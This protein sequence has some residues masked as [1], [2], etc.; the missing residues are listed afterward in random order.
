MIH[1]GI[2]NR[3]FTDDH[4]PFNKQ[5]FKMKLIFSSHTIILALAY[6][7]DVSD[8]L[9]PNRQST[10]SSRIV[11]MRRHL[12]VAYA[13]KI[14][15]LDTL[16]ASSSAETIDAPEVAVL[17]ARDVAAMKYR[18]LQRK[19]KEMGL[20]GTGDTAELRSR[21]MGK[22]GGAHAG[23]EGATELTE[24]KHPP[25][26]E[27]AA[28]VIAAITENTERGHWKKAVRKLKKLGKYGDTIPITVYENVLGACAEGRLSGAR[29]AEPAR[30]I[31]ENM[32]RADYV[33]PSEVGNEC[34]VNSLGTEVGGS[35]D[36]FG[37]IDTA[38]AMLAAMEASGSY[39]T[40]DAYA[41]VVEALSRDGSLDEAVLL[42]RAM[43]VEK[44]FTPPLSM[45]GN[46]ALAAARERMD[47]C[48]MNV[49]SLAKA[50]GYE[51]DSVGAAESGR[52]LL[53]AGLIAAERTDNLRLGLRILTAAKESKTQPDPCD[54]MVS[55]SSPAAQRASTLI[56]KRSI[57]RAVTEDNWK[58]AVRILQLMPVRGIL[59]STAIWRKVVTLCAKAGKS[60]KATALLLDWI[61]LA[62]Q[63]KV[64]KPPQ[65]VF[66][67][68]VNACEMCGEEAL[69]VAVLESM[70][71]TLGTSG[72]LIT[73]N[74][75]LKRLA[76]AGNFLA[77]EGI[78]I[79]M[80]ESGVEPNVVSYTTAIAACAQAKNSK[81]ATEWLKRMISRGIKPNYH[82]YNTVLAACLDGN[83]E[84]TKRASSV[85]A[86]M[87]A[88][89]DQEIVLGLKGN[90]NLKSVVPDT[91][92]KK[93]AREVMKQLRQ[94]WR[95]GDIDMRVAKATIRPP[96][97]RIVDFDKS[98]VNTRIF[99]D[100][101]KAM[102]GME[103]EVKSDTNEHYMEY[104]SIMDIHSAG[105]RAA[106][107]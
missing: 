97:L 9:L 91:Y 4:S 56:H 37:G 75:A 96:F 43:V 104:V 57:E 26:D 89:V 84:S 71:K 17:T 72:D 39:V 103:A 28:D 100:L 59:P 12:S 41:S 52:N 98:E 3:S 79:G 38:L 48:V 7:L 82:T 107:V 65:S 64:E 15:Y 105:H 1:C 69:T 24:P 74:I 53:A 60:R 42:I 87:M 92:S 55:C 8:A 106:E 5:I 40:S 16:G 32:A 101:Q 77:C 29:A 70:K 22:V 44:S 19:C 50:A 73:L 35:H 78:M 81:M 85:A 6:S 2:S 18:M 49:L 63:G 99:E 80:L 83:F 31:M 33:I 45:L 61:S 10:V 88:A 68:V 95:D 14:G 13:D 30:K 27:S 90:P 36:T 46:A 51:F 86:E 102:A 34:I 66:N 58:L 23:I 62:D 21:L 94:N 11:P 25:A 47:D 20:G 54:L 76:K 93:L 67:S